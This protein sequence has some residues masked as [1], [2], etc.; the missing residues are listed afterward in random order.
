MEILSIRF[1]A[2]R[3]CAILFYDF[4]FYIL[5]LITLLLFPPLVDVC[6]ANV[7]VASL[8]LPEYSRYNITPGLLTMSQRACQAIITVS[9]GGKE[10]NILQTSGILE[11]SGA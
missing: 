6:C 7:R 8:G 4:C 2:I 1:Y 9:K 5:V 11:H 3:F 10:I